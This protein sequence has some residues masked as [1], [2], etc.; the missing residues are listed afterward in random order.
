[1][2]DHSS[3]DLVAQRCPGH[4][5]DDG[6]PVRIRSSAR[7]SAHYPGPPRVL[8]SSGQ[9]VGDVDGLSSVGGPYV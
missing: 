5:H 1:M 8:V 7:S 9:Q 6:G 2:G 4:G 3:D